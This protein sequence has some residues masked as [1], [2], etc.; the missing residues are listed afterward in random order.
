MRHRRRWVAAYLVRTW[1]WRLRG[2]RW[3]LHSTR[4][5]LYAPLEVLRQLRV[6]PAWLLPA[7]AG[8][9]RAL[10]RALATRR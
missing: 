3:A 2:G 4:R 5:G 1:Q 8:L 6:S 10:L 7:I 9:D